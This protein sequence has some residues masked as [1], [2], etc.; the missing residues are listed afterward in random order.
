M[1]TKVI[2]KRTPIAENNQQFDISDEPNMIEAYHS[3]E[4]INTRKL[5]TL[6]GEIDPTEG[7]PVNP[8]MAA[9]FSKAEQ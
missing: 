2:N 1:T 6:K 9:A 4:R 3:L 5:L 8:V 7:K